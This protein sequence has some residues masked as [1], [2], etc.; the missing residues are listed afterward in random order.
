MPILFYFIKGKVKYFGSHKLDFFHMLLELTP[1]KHNTIYGIHHI[2]MN[3]HTDTFSY[4]ASS[5][6]AIM[7]L[8]IR[9]E[10]T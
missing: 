3:L 1:C 7:Y 4:A 9:F 5:Q 10:S 6:H 8:H 2:L